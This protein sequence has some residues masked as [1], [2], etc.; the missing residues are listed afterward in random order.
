MPTA[1]HPVRS[2]VWRRRIRKALAAHSKQGWVY[3]LDRVTGKP[4]I[5]MEEKPVPQ[6]PRQ[7]TAATQPVPAGDPTA[8]QCA[9]TV[10]QRIRASAACSRRF[11][12]IRKSRSPQPPAIGR[13]ALTIRNPAYLFFANRGLYAKFSSHRPQHRSWER[14]KYGLITA[15]DSRTNKQ[16]WQKEVPYL[17]GFGSGVLATAGG[18]G[19]PR[20]DGW[21]FSALSIPGRAKN[22]GAFRQASERMPP[23]PATRS[24]ASNMSRSRPAVAAT[25]CAKPEAIWCGVSNWAG[26]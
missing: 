17:A 2:G 10:P 12:T 18:L 25:V 4:L 5:P 11:G 15:L 13:Q 6:E 20:R 1:G 3:I 7:K 16:V 14:V 22:S 9:E 8:P 26:V 19:F 23:Q 21:I 24:Q